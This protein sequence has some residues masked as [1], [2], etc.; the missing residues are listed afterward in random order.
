[1]RYSIPMKFMAVALCALTLLAA[2]ASGIA[3]VLMAHE[4]FS[5]PETIQ[6]QHEEDILWQAQ[7]YASD[8]ASIWASGKYGEMPQIW[9][10]S[11]LENAVAGPS[12]SHYPDADARALLQF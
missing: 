6:Q 8:A 7:T 1:M 4:G 5:D 12:S 11:R 9:F 3:L 10:A 2:A